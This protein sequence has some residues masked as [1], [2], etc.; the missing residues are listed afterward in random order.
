MSATAIT[1]DTDG[2]VR[3]VGRTTSPA[4]TTASTSTRW[5]TR[6]G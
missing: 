2:R 6:P 4:V 3:T 1:L 5:L